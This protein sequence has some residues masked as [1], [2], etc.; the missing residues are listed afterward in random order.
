[1]III[2][3]TNIARARRDRHLIDVSERQAGALQGVVDDRRGELE[4]VARGHL[5]D[6]AAV[7]VV[8][9]LRGDD[10]RADL[11]VAGDDGGAGVVAGGL[12]CEQEG[13]WVF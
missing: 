3:N 11:A 6:D 5:G 8:H 13:H 9:A 7:L 12:D 4:V 1:M 10:V 2:L